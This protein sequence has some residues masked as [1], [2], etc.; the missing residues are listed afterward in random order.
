MELGLAALFALALFLAAGLTVDRA[1]PT[2]SDAPTFTLLFV[3]FVAT[4]LLMVPLVVR[5]AVF[6]FP[7]VSALDRA[8]VLFVLPIG[9]DAAPLVADRALGRRLVVAFFATFKNPL[10]LVAVHQPGI[11]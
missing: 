6:F 10:V 4:L 1:D 7:V 2:D 9:R 8:A 5:S 3:L 11:A